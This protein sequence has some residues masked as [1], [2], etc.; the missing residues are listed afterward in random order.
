M[1][2]ILVK[3]C[4]YSL[5]IDQINHFSNKK[6]VRNTYLA[7][8]LDFGGHFGFIFETEMSQN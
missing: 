1:K 7:T 8:I 2:L 4:I 6:Y 5:I 3:S